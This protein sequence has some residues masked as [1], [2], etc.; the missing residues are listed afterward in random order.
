[1]S[2]CRIKYEEFQPFTPRLGPFCLFVKASWGSCWASCVNIYI[3]YNSVVL[4][5][6]K[7]EEEIKLYDVAD[8]SNGCGLVALKQFVVI[9]RNAGEWRTW[10]RA[11]SESADDT[12]R[13]HYHSSCMLPSTTLRLCCLRGITEIPE[14]RLGMKSSYNIKHNLSK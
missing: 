4:F 1:M 8:D 7:E 13:L 12:N 6:Y 3:K 11:V 14:R 2:C 10:Q 5:E 9:N